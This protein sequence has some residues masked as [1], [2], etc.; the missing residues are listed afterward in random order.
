MM[1]LTALLLLLSGLAGPAIASQAVQ[2]RPDVAAHDGRVTLGDLFDG[3]G[4]AS[5]VVV[6]AGS[7]GATVVLDAQRLQS[8]AMAHGLDWSNPQGMRRVIAR[9]P[10]G[11]PA[12]A[13]TASVLVYAR[14]L[15]AGEVVQP[16]DL[17]WSK[18]PA[19]G[20]PL[21]APR[22]ADSI[23]GQAARRP[24][25]AGA[26]A[27]Q[28]DVAPAQVIKKDDIVSVAYAVGGVKLVL[29]AK[30]L[31]GAAA[32]ESLDV[33]NPASKKVI[34]AVASGPGEAVVG[35]EADRLKAAV[36]TD[37]KLFAALH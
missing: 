4:E 5:A 28:R 11:G 13:R 3:A 14:D 20:A 33:M 30:A 31:R 16:E 6:A 9:A 18:S 17:V 29:Q 35:P 37:P 1:R 7:Q 10:A 2:L 12:A 25:R 26:A 19:Y 15:N 23:I 32:G 34:Q 24:L 21:D 8:I 22:D 36:R 27:A